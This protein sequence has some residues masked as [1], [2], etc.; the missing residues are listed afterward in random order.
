MASHVLLKRKAAIVVC[1]VL[2]SAN[3]LQAATDSTTFTVTAS[4]APSCDVQATAHAFGAY[5]PSA[6]SPLD[7]TS[8]ISVYCT[9]G[10]AYAVSLNSGSGGGS[11]AGRAMLSGSDVLVYNL[12]TNNARTT[13]W[14][15]G[16]S[17][18]GTVGGTGS[19]LLTANNHTVHGRIGVGQDVPPG[20]Y[21]SIVTV[22]VNF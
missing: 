13:V 6:A 10:T 11:F 15:D 16:S 18:T 14:G 20:S 4:V 3:A 19:G 1:A 21:S 22:T 5:S 2:T 12:F 9:Q 8:T 7:T 17:S